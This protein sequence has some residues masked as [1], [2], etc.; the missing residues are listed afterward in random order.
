MVHMQ[1]QSITASVEV[2]KEE[3]I[4]RQRIDLEREI[5]YPSIFP[6]SISLMIDIICLSHASLVSRYCF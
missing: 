3:Q 1:F 2:G 6:I 5:T 4:I